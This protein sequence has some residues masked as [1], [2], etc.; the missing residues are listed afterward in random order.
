MKLKKSRSQFGTQY[1]FIAP[2]F[3]AFLFPV[4]GS[5]LPY[6]LPADLNSPRRE[7]W[8]EHEWHSHPALPL[9]QGNPYRRGAGG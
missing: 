4:Y 8:G 1:V 2:C 9:N 5:P 3:A 7:D 6:T